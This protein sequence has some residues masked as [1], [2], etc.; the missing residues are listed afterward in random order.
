MARGEL[1]GTI[2]TPRGDVTFSGANVVG[3]PA[4]TIRILTRGSARAAPGEKLADASLN[5]EFASIVNEYVRLS[6]PLRDIIVQVAMGVNHSLLSAK[7]GEQWQTD[8][9]T[10]QDR[11]G[12]L[13]S[14]GNPISSYQEVNAN[15]EQAAYELG[16][17][18]DHALDAC[19]A[20]AA[21]ADLNVADYFIRAVQSE[22]R[23]GVAKPG[24]AADP[25]PPT[26]GWGYC[27][28]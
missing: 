10:L 25:P 19:D 26:T 23:S 17:S 11:V 12:G 27:K 22:L 4:V 14:V 7:L 2:S 8:E 1:K 15:L 18:E 24:D 6:S 28:P 20:R 5:A 13:P 16:A 21:T 3:S 9:K